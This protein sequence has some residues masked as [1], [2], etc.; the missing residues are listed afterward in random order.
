MP[1]DQR[2]L[3]GVTLRSVA[4]GFFAMVAMAVQIQF[5]DVLEGNS[6]WATDHAFALQALYCFIALSLVSGVI[7]ALF[8]RRILTRPEMLCILFALAM[9]APLMGQG[10]W[11]RFVSITATIP[12]T[13]DFARIDALS[14]RL[15]PHGPNLLEGALDEGAEPRA[16]A[17]GNV[18]WDDV[19]YGDDHRARLPV[20]ENDRSGQASSVKVEIPVE[21]DGE[22]VLLLGEP[23]LLSVL[24]KPTD[25]GPDATTFCRVYYDDSEQFGQEAFSSRAASEVTYL[26]KQGFL[27]LGTYGFTFA[28]KAEKRVVVEFGLSGQGRLELADPKLMDVMA[29]ERAYR[30]RRIVDRE[31]YEAIPPPERAGLVLRPDSFFS[32]DGLVFLVTAYIP[33]ADWAGPLL[34]WTALVYLMTLS[35]FA[36]MVIMRRQ[37]IDNERYPLP[38]ARALAPLVGEESLGDA[39]LPPVWKNPIMWYG[40]GIGLFW[41]LMKAWRLYNPNVPDMSINLDLKPYFSDPAWGRMWENVTFEVTAVFVGLAMFLELNILISL[42]LGYFLFRSEFWVAKSTGLDVYPQFPYGHHQQVAS[43]IAYGL[44]VVFLTRKYLW[45]TIRAAVSGDRE[46]SEGEA[47]SYRSAYLMLIVCTVGA[48]LWARYVGVKPAGFLVYFAFIILCGFVA[49]KFRAECGPPF[50]HYFPTRGFLLV[51]LFGGMAFFGPQGVLLYVIIGFLFTVATFLMLPGMQLEQMELGRMVRLRPRHVLYTAI[52]G[53]LGGM[54]LGGWVF[55]SNAYAIGGDNMT[56]QWA[57]S[58]KSW[59]FNP[60]NNELNIATNRYIKNTPLPSDGGLDPAYW[61]YMISAGVTVLLA[62]LR[63]IFAGFWFHPIGFIAGPSWMMFKIWGSCLVA[64]AIRSIVLKLGGA[65]TVREKLLP[66]ALG[67]FLSG[68]AAYF[69]LGLY[70][71]YLLFFHPGDERF[72]ILF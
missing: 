42:V 26:H 51:S 59:Q 63:Q 6:A 16:E 8:R 18:R 35:L 7:Y 39:A 5:A 22:T 1:P 68:V 49:A 14:D 29:L 58:E 62:G 33:V 47:I 38:L 43:Y 11:Q 15:W 64:W 3:P 12:R 72:A 36:V 57:F 65:A 20:I 13:A 53:V 10:F 23:Y 34:A 21:R 71:G 37:W 4:A 27:R 2:D 40:F 56:H 32:R 17:V 41:C 61:A 48:A 9:G 24:A 70:N 28:A 60:Y 50:S 46:A 19:A 44:V 66:F 30:G 45:R 54:T 31:E 67:F 52:L 55:L 69:L 25:L